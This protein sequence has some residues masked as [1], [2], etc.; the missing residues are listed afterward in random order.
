[1]Y[2][3]LPVAKGALLVAICGNQIQRTHQTYKAGALFRIA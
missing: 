3:L 2:A 1:M